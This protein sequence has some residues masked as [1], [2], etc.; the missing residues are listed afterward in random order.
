MTESDVHT[1]CD[2]EKQGLLCT[3]KGYQNDVVKLD[4]VTVTI[5]SQSKSYVQQVLEQLPYFAA[6]FS[7]RW[8][9]DWEENDE[10]Q[11]DIDGCDIHVDTVGDA[12]EGDIDA[13]PNDNIKLKSLT[14]TQVNVGDNLE[15]GLD[16]FDVLIN[17]PQTMTID[18]ELPLSSLKALL[19]CQVYFGLNVIDRNMIHKYFELSISCK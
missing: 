14:C 11:N 16:V 4:M 12:S 15:F 19:Q 17:I 5:N 2:D 7:S 3:S 8:M 13:M 1:S 6:K 18:P 10:K 9:N